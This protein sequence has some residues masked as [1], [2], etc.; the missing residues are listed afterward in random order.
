M[1]S[2]ACPQCSYGAGWRVI[3]PS[4]CRSCGIQ[5]LYKRSIAAISLG[6]T[7]YTPI[8][9]PIKKQK[10]LGIS[11][12]AAKKHVGYTSFHQVK[13]RAEIDTKPLKARYQVRALMPT[14][15]RRHRCS[16]GLLSFLIQIHSSQVVGVTIIGVCTADVG[17]SWRSC[18][19]M[20]QVQGMPFPQCRAIQHRVR[21]ID[22]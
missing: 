17:R 16:L 2:W 8:A 14:V 19:S 9:A 5:N 13:R 11:C 21:V 18:W 22:M 4:D 15:R 6:S 7:I 3:S 20:Q 1:A 12:T 10:V